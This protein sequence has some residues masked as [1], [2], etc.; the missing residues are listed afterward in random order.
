MTPL[1]S[2]HERF[3]DFRL[4]TATQE[5][6][7]KLVE[8]GAFRPDLHARIGATELKLPPL[9]ERREDVLRL[10]Q[11]ALSREAVQATASFTARFVEALCLYEWPY[12]VREV[13]QLAQVLRAVSKPV[14]TV[15]DLPERMLERA[16]EGQPSAP[17]TPGA[18]GSGRREAWMLRHAQELARLKV[19]L[20][21]ANGNVSRA[22]RD[23]GIPRHHAMRLLAAETGSKGEGSA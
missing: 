14:F 18:P 4:V 17:S 1:G 15:E 21:S 10:F 11:H 13:V 20:A 22:A 19:A 3:V 5:S 16:D 6:L 9:R 23:A 7:A 12:N 8:R 2:T